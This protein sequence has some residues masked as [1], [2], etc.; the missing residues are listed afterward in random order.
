MNA[1]RS[2]QVI[3]LP[4]IP[5]PLR[6]AFRY[7]CVIVTGDQ[8]YDA[9]TSV[10]CDCLLRIMLGVVLLPV[11]PLL[12]VLAYTDRRK[13]MLAHSSRA[14]SIRVWRLIYVFFGGFSV[15]DALFGP[16]TLQRAAG[17]LDSRGGSYQD[18]RP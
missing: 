9:S 13:R 11:L 12:L 7:G 5:P 6:L 17:F 2:E 10:A 4:H 3:R 1:K 18:L 16:V 14:S 15:F 8:A